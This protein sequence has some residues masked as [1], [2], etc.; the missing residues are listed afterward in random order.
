V[1]AFS[2]AELAYLTDVRTLARI[3]TVGADG[4]PHF[5]P[6]GWSY[7]PKPTQSTFV[8]EGSKAPRSS[9]TSRAAGALRL[10]STTS[11]ARTLGGPAR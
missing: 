4:T 5:V 6:V 2:A 3:A 8:V 7:N 11:S 10:Q 1:S 9:A